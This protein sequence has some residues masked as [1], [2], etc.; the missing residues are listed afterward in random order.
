M[1]ILQITKKFPYPVKDGEV[2]GI[3]NL[4][5]GFAT[6]G[7]EVTVLSLNTRKHYFNP[8]ELPASIQKIARF[9]AVDIDTKLNP[10]KAFVNLFTNESYNIERFYSKEFEQKIVAIL[11]QEHFDFVLLEGI[12]LMRY[13]DILKKTLNAKLPTP[14]SELPTKIVLRPQNVEY[15]I[16]E[17]LRD[18]ETNPLKKWYLAL[19]AKRMKAFE[20]KQMN[21]A[22]LLIPVS[23]NDL[24]IFKLK[25]CHLPSIAIPTGYVYDVLPAI[26]S[27]MEENAVAF[28]GGMDWMP[29]REGVEWFLEKVWV[30][31]LTQLPHAK[32]YLAG[33][34]FPDEIRTLQVK[35]LVIV[36]EV[37][38]AKAFIS[39]K[40]ISI[41]PLFAGSG[42]RV[43]IVEAMALGRAVISTS[44]G[45]ESL[46]YTHGKDILIA[47]D[48]Q[49][50][51][52]EVVRVLSNKTLRLS[53]GNFAQQLVDEV[54][55]NR[56]IS[57][58]ILD[59]VKQA[60]AW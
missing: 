31:V 23:Q 51:A 27:G 35:G 48:A 14:N 56:K 16:W 57:Q 9:I 6:L 47:D 19:L 54:Y 15:V 3:L 37:E 50:F 36:G 29:N 32:F 45:A 12:Y 4:T 52:D 13:I 44:I 41:V 7:H 60:K 58:R 24:D 10:A 11:E 30:K 53:L 28:I 18:T 59:F 46:A 38:D 17:R 49:T 1:K 42:M 22:D 33:R 21:Q 2:I 55:D 25:G 43:K 34:N 26:D 5:M 8:K 39:S 40:T 20:I